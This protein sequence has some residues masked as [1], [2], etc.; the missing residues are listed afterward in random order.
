[1]KVF[2]VIFFGMAVVLTACSNVGA[3]HC[4]IELWGYGIRWPAIALSV[5]SIVTLCIW[6]GGFYLIKHYIF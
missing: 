2:V 3:W 5:M 1:M 6:I 4:A